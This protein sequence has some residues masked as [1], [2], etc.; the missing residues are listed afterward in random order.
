MENG[1]E[2]QA[3]PTYPAHRAS[4][5]RVTSS[6][7]QPLDAWQS[8]WTSTRPQPPLKPLLLSLSLTLRPSSEH[9]QVSSALRHIL[10]ALTRVMALCTGLAM[11]GLTGLHTPTLREPSGCCSHCS[12]PRSRVATTYF[13]KL[14]LLPAAL[15]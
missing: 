3:P 12:C 1:A 14:L 10:C 13:P 15:I 9:P 4:S 5:H 2:A 7:P 11:C 8:C 6:S